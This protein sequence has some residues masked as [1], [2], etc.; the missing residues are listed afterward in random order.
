[1]S[2]VQ[3]QHVLGYTIFQ[4]RVEST[5]VCSMKNTYASVLFYDIDK[6][7]VDGMPAL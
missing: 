1:M 3:D 5:R 4:V 7:Y 6:A 2:L